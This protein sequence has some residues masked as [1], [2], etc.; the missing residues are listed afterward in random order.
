MSMMSLERRRSNPRAIYWACM[1]GLSI[2][3]PAV[4]V[5]PQ[6]IES[7]DSNTIKLGSDCVYQGQPGYHVVAIDNGEYTIRA[8]AVDP[9]IIVTRDDIALNSRWVPEG[10]R[11]WGRVFGQ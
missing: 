5:L 9:E 3:I 4:A 7:Y 2:G 11:W 10:H 6:F 1:I 8:S